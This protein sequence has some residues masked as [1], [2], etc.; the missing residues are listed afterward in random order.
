M[1][2]TKYVNVYAALLDLFVG[3]VGTAFVC[4]VLPLALAWY[5]NGGYNYNILNWKCKDFP[6]TYSL[7]RWREWI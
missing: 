4:M 1:L 6:H 5:R 3:P 7:D 2:Y